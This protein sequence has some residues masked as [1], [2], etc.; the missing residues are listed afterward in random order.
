M[1]KKYYQFHPA[2][3]AV[4]TIAVAKAPSKPTTVNSVRGPYQLINITIGKFAT[5]APA[6]TTAK[7][8]KI[9]YTRTREKEKFC[10][11]IWEYFPLFLLGN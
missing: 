4:G 11:L 2:F 9:C 3:I 8:A 10:L 5:S 7:H 1:L 6:A